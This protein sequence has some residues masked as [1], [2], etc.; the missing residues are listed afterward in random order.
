MVE[1]NEPAKPAF[2]KSPQDMTHWVDAASASVINPKAIGGSDFDAAR[3]MMRFADTLDDSDDEYVVMPRPVQ[4]QHPPRLKDYRAFVQ[5]SE[6]Y[7]WLLA[8]IGQYGQL[9]W[10]E[11][12]AI[13]EISAQIQRDLRAREPLRKMSHRRPLSVAKIDLHLPWHPRQFVEDKNMSFLANLERTVCITGSWKEAQ[14][15]TIT[16]YMRQTWP[17]T[18]ECLLDVLEKLSRQDTGKLHMS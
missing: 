7:R 4:E 6:S 2:Q 9:S 11:R 10:A 1:D 15:T 5:P 12:D 13:G 18:C 14:A 17:V 8:K 16:G 3:E